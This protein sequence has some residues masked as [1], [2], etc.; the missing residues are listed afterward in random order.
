MSTR[1]GEFVTL[2]DVVKEVGR[3]AARFLFLTRHYDSTLDFDLEVAKQKS[4]DNPVYYVQYVHARISSIVR[5]GN[6]QGARSGDIWMMP[7]CFL[8]DGPRVLWAHEY[9]HAADRP[10]FTSIP[11]Q[12][13]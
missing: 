12:I 1:V 10:D 4:N 9:A 11:D 13:P 3:D 8:V 7:G 5:K 6:E 2:Q